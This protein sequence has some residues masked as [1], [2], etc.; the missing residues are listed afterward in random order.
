[1]NIFCSQQTEVCVY[2][3]SVTPQMMVLCYLKLQTSSKLLK[4]CLLFPQ[5]GM[6]LTYDPSSAAMQNG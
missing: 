5:A 6:T 2:R 4:S 3:P 1:M